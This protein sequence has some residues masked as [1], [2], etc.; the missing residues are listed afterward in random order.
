MINFV[1]KAS[2]AIALCG[3]MAASTVSAKKRD[4]KGT[5]TV[6]MQTPYQKL[7]KGKKCETV[8]GLVALHKM[9]GKLYLEIPQTLFGKAMVMGTTIVE[10]TNNGFGSVGEKPMGLIPVMFTLSDTI[11]SIGYT[12]YAGRTDNPLIRKRIEE[13]AR[14]ATLS[15]F[16]VKAYN[17]DSSAV[18]VE[19]TDFLLD[20]VYIM[21]PFSSNSP[22]LGYGGRQFSKE[23][24]KD[25]C[26]IRNIRSYDDNFSIESSMSYLVTVKD[27]TRTYMDGQPFTA[28]LSR[29]FMLLPEERMEIRRG[30]PRIGIFP[31]ISADFSPSGMGV[32]EYAMANHWRLEPSDPAAYA[33]GELTTPVKPI[34]FYVDD[35]FPQ[36]W[37]K[38]VK[39]GVEQWQQ[40]FE[41]IGFKE[42]VV[43]RDYP[44]DDPSF[45]PNNLKYSCVVYS[46]SE[47]QNSMGPSWVDPRTGE[48]LSAS[49]YLYHN[50]VKLVRNWRF[51]QTAAAD[52]DVRKVD[53]DQ[54]DIGECIRYVVSHEIG[55]CLGLMHNMSASAAIPTDSLRSPTFTRVHGTT[56]SIMDYARYNYVAQ[57]GDKERGVRLIPPALGVYD[58]FTIKWLYTPLPDSTRTQTLTRWIGERSGD[59]A[60]RYGKQQLFVRLD[61]SSIEEDLGD[62]AMR[63]SAYGISNLKYILS[64]LDFWMASQDPDYNFREQIY[65]EICSQ[66]VRLVNNVLPNIG[67]VYV[68]ERYQ[69]DA[70]PSFSTVDK[71]KQRRAVQFVYDQLGNMGW[72]EDP[73]VMRNL[74][75]LD[76]PVARL[77]LSLFEA[78]LN[79]HASVA[80]CASKAEGEKYDQREFFDDIY[81]LVW[82]PTKQRQ[83]LTNI[84]CRIQSTFVDYLL[85]RSGYVKMEKK[86]ARLAVADYAPVQVELPEQIAERYPF[87]WDRVRPQAAD[88]YANWRFDT[89]PPSE[90][91]GF[92]YFV[93]VSPPNEQIDHICFEMANRALKLM[94]QSLP[95][96]DPNT[97]AHYQLLIL[98][99]EKAMKDKA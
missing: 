44:T 29:S 37:R 30:D 82:A 53:F 50:L 63:S 8:R 9:E 42:A 96:A 60:Y 85:E 3:A 43:A 62:D 58:Y 14:P 32:R 72:L 55:H 47:V 40:A 17:A 79:L 5:D 68:N 93:F 18:V 45:D 54:K 84:Q 48:I 31:T 59:P 83:P 25:R 73:E 52:P 33:R 19:A 36:A 51:V 69:G 66:Y 74:P 26:Y 78:L 61:P 71:A 95:A 12:K 1:F 64:N 57:P 94:K 13:S 80:L 11:V 70:L 49:V 91:S 98:R 16:G 67:G 97:R 15:A 87:A 23:F 39:Q 24:Q 46:P 2:V 99:I 81:T 34:V 76:G 20:D 21:G 10:T 22:A 41:K 35:A 90:Q 77:E 27:K 88:P 4:K 86:G 65:Y 38:Y 75:L 6:A 92:G 7:F 89:R 56:Y 28:V